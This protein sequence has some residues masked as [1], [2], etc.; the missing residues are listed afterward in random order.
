MGKDEEGWRERTES[1]HGMGHALV[2]LCLPRHTMFCAEMGLPYLSESSG[3]CGGCERY[4]Q[5]K[6]NGSN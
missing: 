2:C 3:S 6:I 1:H 4:L 5:H